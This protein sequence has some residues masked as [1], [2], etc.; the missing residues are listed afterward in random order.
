MLYAASNAGSLAALLAY[1]FL[2]ESNFTLSRQSSLW[3]IGFFALMGAI[4]LA[5]LFPVLAGPTPHEAA[6]VRS[7]PVAW[8]MRLKWLVYAALPSSLLLGVTGYVTTDIASIPL[9]WIAPLAIY[10]GT[11][12]LIFVARPVSVWICLSFAKFNWR[13]KTM[14]SW[15]DDPTSS[16]GSTVA[17]WPVARTRFEIVK[18]LKPWNVALS[19]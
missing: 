16:A 12:V 1:P 17:L 3:S 9:L 2:L 15:V 7:S 8:R 5:A 4:A 13:E 10:L 6:A 18:A 14:I 11:F 19:L